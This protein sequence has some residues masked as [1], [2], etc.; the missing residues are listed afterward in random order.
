[1]V[2][3]ILTKSRTK[4]KTQIAQLATKKRSLRAGPR[5]PRPAEAAVRCGGTS[6]VS[7]AARKDESTTPWRV[8]E[9]CFAAISIA[10][11]SI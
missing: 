8:V 10:S 4:L 1:M 9:E 6:D 7:S 2:R 3:S 5:T 11:A